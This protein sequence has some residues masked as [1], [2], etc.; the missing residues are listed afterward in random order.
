MADE[1]I[2]LFKTMVRLVLRKYGK[3]CSV[4]L[5]HSLSF[6]LLKAPDLVTSINVSLFISIVM[7]QLMLLMGPIYLLITFTY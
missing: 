1:M 3:Q 4:P 7:I 2:M 5:L 6:D